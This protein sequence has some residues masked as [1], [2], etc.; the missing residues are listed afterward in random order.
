[1][2]LI[3]RES[4]PVERFEQDGG[5]SCLDQ[6]VSEGGPICIGAAG[7]NTIIGIPCFV[8]EAYLYKQEAETLEG[9]KDMTRDESRC[10]K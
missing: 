6:A 10:D 8:Y 9:S 5:K 3:Y 4:T 7:H 2:Q 1:L